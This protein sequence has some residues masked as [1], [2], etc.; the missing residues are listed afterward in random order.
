[1]NCQET[2]QLLHPYVDGELDLTKS[3][4]IEQHLQECPACA[5]SQAN[6]QKLRA[7]LMAESPYYSASPEL[8]SRIRTAVR[9]P[10]KPRPP[11]RLSLQR[12]LALAASVALIAVAGWALANVL[13]S[14]PGEEVLVEALVASHIRS[15]MLPNRIF[16]K[17]SSDSHVIK[18]WFDGKVD[19]SPPV[20]DL[21]AQGFPLV[22][23]RLDYLE[24]RGVAVL[25]Y[26]R[27]EHYINLFVW[28]APQGADAAPRTMTR[29]G[30]Q[31]VHWR[32]SGMTCWAVSN[33]NAEELLEFAQLV[34]DK[35]L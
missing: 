2:R 3:L 19:F 24:N 22:G 30:Y 28:P 9:R 13:I 7:K 35:R 14:R 11:R 4:E 16:D 32:Q 26:K 12:W 33:L 31:L 5:Q 29:N 10:G 1:V 8:R 27:R 34:Q 20:R 18:P 21:T 25:V 17:E 15:Q 23:A 6:L